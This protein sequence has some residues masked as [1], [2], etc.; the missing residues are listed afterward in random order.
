MI[1][2][3]FDQTVGLKLILQVFEIKI[4]LKFIQVAY[5]SV[6]ILGYKV[7]PKLNLKS[8]G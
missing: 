8:R 7:K 3:S 6:T 5:L 4:Y 1:F 2:I